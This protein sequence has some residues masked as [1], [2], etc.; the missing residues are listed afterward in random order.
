LFFHF[1]EEEKGVMVVDGCNGGK[2]WEE[3]GERRGLNNPSKQNSLETKNYTR[4]KS[5]C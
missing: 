2:A 3:R 5:L 1:V 4:G